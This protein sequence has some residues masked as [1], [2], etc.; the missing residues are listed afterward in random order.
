[1][2]PIRNPRYALQKLQ[3][4]H[5]GFVCLKL[6]SEVLTHSTKPRRIQ[7]D[8]IRALSVLVRLYL[9]LRLGIDSVWF[10]LTSFSCNTMIIYPISDVF[11]L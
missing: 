10:I 5:L 2:Y 6:G 4:E 7:N 3:L 11:G 1:M 8:L 9:G